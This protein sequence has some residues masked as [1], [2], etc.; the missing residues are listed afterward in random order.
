MLSLE[1][2]YE[3]GVQVMS[4]VKSTVNY[5]KNIRMNNFVK[6]TDCK[7]WSGQVGSH[8]E[9]SQAYRSPIISK[10]LICTVCI[11]PQP[12]IAALSHVDGRLSSALHK[13]SQF[14]PQS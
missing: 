12:S 10:V 3:I 7:F 4:L 6:C 9:W 1:T 13:C 8:N 2:I 5:T 11:N 14:E